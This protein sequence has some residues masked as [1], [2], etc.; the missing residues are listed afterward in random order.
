MAAVGL[1]LENEYPDAFTFTETPEEAR[2]REE[3]MMTGVT[4]NGSAA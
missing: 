4:G 1:Y 3:K 2:E